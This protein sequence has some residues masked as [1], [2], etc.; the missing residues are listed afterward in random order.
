MYLSLFG[1]LVRFS[2]LREFSKTTGLFG[3]MGLGQAVQH[4]KISVHFYC[5]F[6][7]TAHLPGA[8]LISVEVSLTLSKKRQK[9]GK[10]RQIDTKIDKHTVVC[11]ELLLQLKKKK[12]Q[13]VMST[14]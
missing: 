2:K 9:L 4:I 1:I 6:F 11:I 3:K 5:S 7:S 8:R 13:I 12:K 14:N 10:D